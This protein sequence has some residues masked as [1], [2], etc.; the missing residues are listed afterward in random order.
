MEPNQLN[1]IQP[2]DVVAYIRQ[3]G[4]K[5]ESELDNKI[6]LFRNEAFENRQLQVPVVSDFDDYCEL[7]E[8]LA[9]K[10]SIIEK[11]TPIQ[12]I[13]DWRGATSD[14][15]RIKVK[16]SSDEHISF[17]RAL[18]SLQATKQALI[19]CACSVLAPSKHHARLRRAEATELIES[20]K[21]AQTEKGSFVLKISCPI[22]AVDLDI[23][24]SSSET[25]P[26]ARKT[27]TLFM[28]SLNDVKILAT[29][30]DPSAELPDTL[31]SNFCNALRNIL[32]DE[33]EIS[34]KWA[35]TL[36]QQELNVPSTI[37]FAP[38]LISKIEH[39]E[40][41]LRPAFLSQTQKIFGTVESLEG[42]LGEDSKRFGEISIRFLLDEDSVLARASVNSTQYEIA[43]RA[44]MLGQTVRVVGLLKLGA[45][46]NRLESVSE[47]EILD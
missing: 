16:T 46:S 17:S 5:Y 43:D 14:S 23:S 21:L 36:T 2:M 4:W 25:V 45:R 41:K 26:F 42:Q 13:S 40:A 1:N 38:A 28:K 11:R 22:D 3:Q 39:I 18:N 6:G 29:N 20:C 19:A 9:E 10:L 27:M 31:S 8:R 12:V 32:V 35:L 37:S 44:H 33:M 47:F 30:D 34:A 24:G 15:I 7:L